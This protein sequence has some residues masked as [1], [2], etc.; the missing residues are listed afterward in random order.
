MHF[1]AAFIPEDT[2]FME[3]CEFVNP[4]MRETF[5]CLLHKDS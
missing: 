3:K 4:E 2:R 5:G 1:Y